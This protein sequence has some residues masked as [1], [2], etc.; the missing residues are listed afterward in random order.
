MS[1]PDN[2]IIPVVLWI[3]DEIGESADFIDNAAQD[4]IVVHPIETNEEGLAKLYTLY[5]DYDAL[6]LDAWGRSAPGKKGADSQ[7]LDQLR[8]QL[9]DLAIRFGYSIPQCVYTGHMGEVQYLSAST[10]K[11]NKEVT[12]DLDRL[13]SWVHA[14]ANA[15]EANR[16]IAAHWDVFGAFREN[17]LPSDKKWEL[18]KLLEEMDSRDAPTIRANNGLCR[19]LVEPVM[20]GLNTLG[21]KYMPGELLLGDRLNADGAIRFLTGQPLEIKKDNVVIKT[22]PKRD[23][24]IPEHLGWMLSTIIKTPTFTGA[25]DYRE[26]HTHYAHRSIVN[27]L[28]ELLIWYHDLI[29]SKRKK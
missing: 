15:R 6:I 11:F 14:Q 3:D 7:S 2:T 20:R 10:P 1:E 8:Q 24:I 9:N 16:I 4:G 21:E 13:F 29:M 28:C 19:Q 12:G 26:K 18:V 25:H 17:L 5:R 27:A 23:K 22:F